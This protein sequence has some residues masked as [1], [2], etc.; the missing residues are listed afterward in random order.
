[1]YVAN[2][3]CTPR[4]SVRNIAQHSKERGYIIVVGP[5]GF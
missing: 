1:M 4:Y 3:L 5:F 2:I